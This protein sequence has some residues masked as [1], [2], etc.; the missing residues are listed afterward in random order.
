MKAE[1]TVRVGATPPSGLA[2]RGVRFGATPS[3]VSFFFFFFLL[4][5]LL[6]Y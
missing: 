4:I 5:Y 2:L 3:L 1:G 6:Q